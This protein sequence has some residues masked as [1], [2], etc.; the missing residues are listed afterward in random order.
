MPI[1][2]KREPLMDVTAVS[3]VFLL[4]YMPKAPEGYTK[5]Y[6]LGLMQTGTPG[7]DAAGL[8][9]AGILGMDDAALVRAFSYWQTAGL[10]RIAADDPLTVEYLRV[11]ASSGLAAG[12]A[13]RKYASLVAALQ[14]VA[15]TRVFSGR[16]LAE[17]YDWIETFRFE[18]ATAVLCVKDCLVRHGARAKL[19]QMNA[20]AKRW[21]D[22]GV[23]TPEEAERYMAR[24]QARCAGAQQLL[25]RWNRN[26]PATED[27]IALYVK[28]TEEWGFDACVIQDA[29][30]EA[31]SSAQPSFR[32]L[33]RILETYRLTGAV[34]EEAAALLRR[35]QDA[36]AE[37]AR[38]LFERAEIRRSP[39][40]S[41]REQIETWHD[42]WHV[43][44]ELLFYAA[45]E[46][47]SAAQPFANIKKLVT[48]WHSA[49]IA[50]VAAAQEFER[51]KGAVPATQAK[52][53][54]AHNHHQRTYS[55]AELAE[56]GINLED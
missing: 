44:A 8:D 49:G 34:T 35:A 21:A 6:L 16:E 23:A 31:T 20:T 15:G 26:R 30:V 55:D 12:D 19:W 42:K 52:R 45:D 9:L 25:K 14:E 29:C 17:I 1:F 11:G 36:A 4:E 7:A 46:S 32:Y 13:P 51:K 41:Q 24:E 56:I 27:E 40:L 53:T 3:N 50:T 10:V 48:A 22:A 39:T 5:V 28:W 33:D 2:L 47:R 54:R 37:L 38:M 18:E 43:D